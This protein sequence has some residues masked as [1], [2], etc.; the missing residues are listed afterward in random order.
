MLVA[1]IV[2]LRFYYYFFIYTLLISLVNFC[3]NIDNIFN[4][5]IAM[6]ILF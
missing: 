3:N 5:D 6:H 1:L 4:V 2:I